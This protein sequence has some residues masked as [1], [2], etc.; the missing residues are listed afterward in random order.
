MTYL[1]CTRCADPAII[2]TEDEAL[3][4]RCAAENLI[5]QTVGFVE[6]KQPQ[7][8]PHTRMPPSVGAA[9][10]AVRSPQAP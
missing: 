1:P 5:E 2:L 7:S 4:S 9:Q 3:C 6:E 10:P 8:S